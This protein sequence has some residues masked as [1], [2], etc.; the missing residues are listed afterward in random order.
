MTHKDIVANVYVATPSYG[1]VVTT[2]YV[3]G[4]LDLYDEAAQHGFGLQVNF[5]S[6]DSL[7]TRARNTM[8]AEFLADARFTHLMWIDGD[9]GFKGADVVRLLQAD[10]AVVAGVYPLKID[11][12]PAGGL[13]EGLP[14]GS[15]KADFRARHAMYP[16]VV[17]GDDALEVDA[18]GF[19]DVLYAPTGFMLIRREVFLALMQRF[20][21][22][23]CRSKL[24][25]RPELDVGASAAFLYAF[26]DTMI[27]PE[28][29]L[30][31][32]EDYAFCRLIES[33]GITP[34]V[35]ARSNLR[36][37]GIAVYEGD[38]ARS[39]GIQ[40]SRATYAAG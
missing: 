24:A 11:G 39:L 29:R 2:D 7:I 10:R 34:A 13:E 23:H 33:I 14:A 6:F 35:D 26:F 32:S 28:S 15:T 12:W 20:P 21:E 3:L 5:N 18:E 1:A 8:V 19:L 36:H 40:R 4:L 9:I 27:D 30:Y 16:A 22:L 38:L 17:R 37:Q 31:L 25:D